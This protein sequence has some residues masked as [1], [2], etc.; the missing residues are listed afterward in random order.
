VLAFLIFKENRNLNGSFYV[1]VVLI[2][3]ALFAQMYV[4]RQKRKALTAS[5][6]QVES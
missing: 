3:L 1:G 4:L 6:P 5:L 2:M